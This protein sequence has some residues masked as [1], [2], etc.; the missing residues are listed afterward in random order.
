M[1]I[2]LKS[3]GS[4][5]SFYVGYGLTEAA[6]VCTVNSG[7]AHEPGSAGKPID[8]TAVKIIDKVDGKGE[9]CIKSESVFSGY[10]DGT[11]PVTG[12]GWLKTG[13]VGYLDEE[14]FLYVSG[15]KANCRCFR[16]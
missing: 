16:I 3:A 12:D 9:I 13:D 5:A 6:S 8:N 14:G 11:S 15:R 4:S 7:R 10:T 1:N 2:C